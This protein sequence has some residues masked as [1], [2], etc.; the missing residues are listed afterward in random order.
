SDQEFTANE[1]TGDRR[2]EFNNS[3]GEM[4]SI[5]VNVTAYVRG[6]SGGGVGGAAAPAEGGTGGSGSSGTG[7]LSAPKVMRI[8]VNPLTKSVTAK[9]L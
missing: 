1:V 3:A 6:A 5:D 4:F 2:L 7:T 9:L 8:T